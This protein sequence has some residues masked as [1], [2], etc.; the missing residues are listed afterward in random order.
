M[1]ALQNPLEQY[2]GGWDDI[3]TDEGVP[4]GHYVVKV[5]DIQLRKN[6]NNNQELS[7][8]LRVQLG[9]HQGS[10]LWLTHYF[11][12]KYCRQL[13]KEDLARAEIKVARP[14]DLF[15]MLDDIV[16]LGLEVSKTTDK[17]KDRDFDKV[18][19]KKFVDL[20]DLDNAPLDEDLPF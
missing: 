13:L 12:R 6:R 4:D 18:R 8:R 2:D 7:W 9:P 16:G 10:T 5:E 19:I 14:S 15:G 20:S 11:H 1:E 3:D 17:G